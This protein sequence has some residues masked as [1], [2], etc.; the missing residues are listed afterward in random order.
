VGL[1]GLIYAAIVVV[2]AV[3]LIPLALRRHDQAARSHSIER[4]SSAMRILARRGAASESGSIQVAPDRL[5]R[6]SLSH[7]DAPAAQTAAPRRPT[8]AAMK[9]AAARRRRV[10]TVLVALTVVV[11]AVSVL[12]L[13]PL[14]ATA[15]P[16]VLVVAFLWLARRQVRRANDSYWD[17][18]AD[19]RPEQSNVVRRVAESGSSAARVD[20]SEGVVRVGTLTAAADGADTADSVE[21]ADNAEDTVGISRADLAA[22]V[23]AAAGAP[24]GEAGRAARVEAVALATS[25]GGS[26]WDPLPVTL[27]TYVDKPAA[28]RSVRTIDLGEPGTWSAGHSAADS[29]TAAAADADGPA[30]PAAEARAAHG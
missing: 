1:T 16:L 13:L 20:A 2:W 18:L 8:R 4:F 21:D 27:P 23:S 5:A 9:A 7:A 25:D 17:H 6:A 3:V 15:V 22:A 28:A 10:L 12:G 19:V 26:L 24:A 29:E 11:G 30:S 14:Y